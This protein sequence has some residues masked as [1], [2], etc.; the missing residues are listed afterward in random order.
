MSRNKCNKIEVRVDS[1]GKMNKM[2]ISLPRLFIF[3]FFSLSILT[4]KRK[5]L[6]K[7][8]KKLLSPYLNT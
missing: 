8:I 5:V 4:I 7:A 6:K 1:L 2:T 3:A